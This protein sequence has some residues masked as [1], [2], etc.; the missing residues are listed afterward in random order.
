M[1]HAKLATDTGAVALADAM[2]EVSMH[3]ELSTAMAGAEV[4]TGVST[5]VH[6]ELS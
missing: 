4:H 1:L 3:T 5:M 2:V 6:T